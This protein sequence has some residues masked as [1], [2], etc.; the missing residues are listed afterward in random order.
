[1]KRVLP[2]LLIVA[3]LSGGVWHLW[4]GAWIHA[5]AHLAQ[6]L[7]EAAWDTAPHGKKEVKPWPWADTWPICRLA[8]PRLGIRRLVLAGGHGEAL[9]FGPGHLFPSAPPGQPGNTVIAGHR[10]THFRFV[11]KLQIGDIVNIETAM[12]QQFEYRVSRIEVVHETQTALLAPMDSA[13]LTLIT[14]FPFDALRSGGPLR[15]IVIAD[16]QRELTPL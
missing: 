12:R 5:K 4:A 2:S 13:R 8:V 1:M 3:L 6:L 10:D 14:C 11:R 15:Y 9:A 7:L 16:M